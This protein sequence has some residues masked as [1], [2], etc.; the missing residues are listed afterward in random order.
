[1]SVIA[2]AAPL[3]FWPLLLF[4]VIYKTLFLA[5]FCG[6][7]WLGRSNGVIPVGPVVVF[8][9]IIAVWPFFIVTALQ[10]GQ[11]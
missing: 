4:Q 8:I 7:I 3:T 10:S 2:L 6:P 5:V 1:M 11:V 9:F